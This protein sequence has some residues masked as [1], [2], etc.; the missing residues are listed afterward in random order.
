MISG[1]S[2]MIFG[3]TLVRLRERCPEPNT[4]ASSC[5][6]ST[7]VVLGRDSARYLRPG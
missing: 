7:T 4:G 5:L 1:F 6:E 2:L 3:S